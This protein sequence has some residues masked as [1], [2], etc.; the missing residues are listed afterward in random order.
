MSQSRH[1]TAS[2]A[3]PGFQLPPAAMEPR[4]HRADGDVEDLGGVRVAEVADVDE[5][6]DV[7]EVVG[8][9]RERGH[10]RVLREPL[11]DAILVEH[12]LAAGL[13]HAVREVVVALL[14]RRLVRPTLEP[15]A[16]V[17]VEVRQDPQ[18][19]RAE[20]GARGVGLP[21]PEGSRIRLLHQILGFLAG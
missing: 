1:P 6:D 3:R 19:P 18:E 12:L 10:D 20:V 17:R 4:H 2:S 15:A 14:E 7:A 21:T 16:A 11:D 9:R 5:D 13:R 8:Q